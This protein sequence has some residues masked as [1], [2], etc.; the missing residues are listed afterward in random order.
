VA[1]RLIIASVDGTWNGWIGRISFLSFKSVSEAEE[2]K[3]SIRRLRKQLFQAF[4]ANARH[5]DIIRP[6]CHGQDLAGR[7][8]V[9]VQLAG[10]IAANNVGA[11]C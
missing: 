2:G 6:T 3:F 4:G 10:S 5:Q 9:V 8:A 1:I 11:T 7:C